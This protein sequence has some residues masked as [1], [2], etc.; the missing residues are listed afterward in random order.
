MLEVVRRLEYLH[1]KNVRRNI[2]K[3]VAT[4]TV[5]CQ[6]H[7]SNLFDTQGNRYKRVHD[8]TRPDPFNGA[9]PAKVPGNKSTECWAYNRVRFI[10]GNFK[11]CKGFRAFMLSKY[12]D[13]GGIH[14]LKSSR[15]W[16][17]RA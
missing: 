5:P 1:L 4:V 2:G 16:A 7:D 15:F 3:Y 13:K 10:A 14:P 6:H 17:V 8:E 12:G 11:K 9:P